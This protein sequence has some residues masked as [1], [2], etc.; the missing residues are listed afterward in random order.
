[1]KWITRLEYLLFA[2]GVV[3]LGFYLSAHLHRA[4][5]S[6]AAMKTFKA[7]QVKPV[8]HSENVDLVSAA[9]DFSSWSQER[10]REYTDGVT[11]HA[12]PAIAILRIP[13]LGL[14]APVLEGTD[15]LTLNVG[16]GRI[17]GTA[18]PDE[19]GNVGIAGHRD[20]F[21]RGLKDVGPGDIIEMITRAHTITYTVERVVIV[22]PDDVSVLQAHQ[23]PSLTLVTCYPFYFV[24]SA[25][26]RYVVQASIRDPNGARPKA[27]EAAG[28]QPQKYAVKRYP[29][30]LLQDRS[31]I[32]QRQKYRGRQEVNGRSPLYHYT[33]FEASNPTV[34]RK[35][36]LKSVTRPAYSTH[37]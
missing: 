24:G 13:K 6:R 18:K 2:L 12:T 23:Q 30:L 8:G 37:L 21:F 25:P 26:K 14:E 11:L 1:M 5:C 31:R 19:N 15:D 36:Y 10:I 22:S 17:K 3:M 4:V 20:G 33:L 35:A 27:V 16:L 34:L 28:F 29:F 9:P 32:Q 7:E